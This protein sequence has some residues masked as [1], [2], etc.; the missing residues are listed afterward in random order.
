[1]TSESEKGLRNNLCKPLK[2]SGGKNDRL[3]KD[4]I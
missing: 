4:V 3:K 1:M 2:K